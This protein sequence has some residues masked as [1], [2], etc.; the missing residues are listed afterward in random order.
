MAKSRKEQVF[1]I[2]KRKELISYKI[3]IEQAG[4]IYLQGN[5]DVLLTEDDLKELEAN[6]RLIKITVREPIKLDV[7]GRKV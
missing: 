1:G 7:H 5:K 6:H 2:I 4:Q 3:V